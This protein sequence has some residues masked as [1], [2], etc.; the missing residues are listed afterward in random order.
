MWLSDVSVKHPIFAIVINLLLIIFGLITLNRLAL[1]EYPAIDP[2][3]ISIETSYPGAAAAT[4]ETRITKILEDRISGIEGIAYI[5][6]N[7]EDGF[8]SIN[9]EF[10][11]NRNIDNAAN[12]VRERVNRVLSDL[13][14]DAE[15][16]EIFKADS[17]NDVIIWLNLSSDKLNQLQLTDYANRYLVDRLA[18]V[19]GVARVRIGG[20][21]RY[22]MR[23][24]I[25][26]IAMAAR[27]ITLTDIE[28]A[29]RANNV[30]L[31]GGRIESKT[32]EFTVRIKRKF[33]T[34]ND[35]AK[36]V[37]RRDSNGHIIRLG[38]VAKIKVAA[39]NRRTELRGNGVNMIGLGVIK[40]SNANTLDV[41]KGIR[42]KVAEIKKSLPT[43]IKLHNSYDSS[44]F[45]SEAVHGVF[46]TFLIALA[47]VVIIIYLFLGKISTVI[48]P[49]ITIPVSIIATFIILY[50]QHYSL[51][52]LTLLALV[53]A[54]GLVVDDSIVVLENI[55]RRWH[56][57]EPPLLASYRGTRQVGFA[58]ISTTVVL[59]AIF[60][61][62][63]LFQG[64]VG[65]LFT[66]F[67]FTLSAAVVFSSIVALTLSPVLCSLI[68]GVG[69][70]ETRLEKWANKIHAFL[71]Y[72]YKKA[73]IWSLAHKK[74]WVIIF[75]LVSA[76]I[77]LLYNL[78]PQE[79]VPEEDRGAFYVLVNGPEGAS[80]SYM[81]KNMRQ[82]E[83]TLMPL[84]NNK[85]ATRVLTIVPR[86]FGR[87]D[88]VNSGFGI[89]VMSHW[90]QRKHSTQA[91]IA[92]IFP[93]LLSV[94]GVQAFPIMR[95]GIAHSGTQQQV[96]FVIGGSN[97]Q[98]LAIWRDTI[99]NY[100]KKNKK[101]L[102]LDSDYKETTPQLIIDINRD[103]AAE[104]GVPMQAIGRT[105][106]TLLGA[107]KVTTYINDDEE[108]EVML[109]LNLQQKQTPRDI[110]YIYVRSSTTNRLIPLSNLITVHEIN[111][112][113][114]LHR[115]NRLRA[116]TISA[117]LAPGYTLDQA[118]QFLEKIALTHLPKTVNIDYKGTSR[119]YKESG[120]QIIFIFI[121]AIMVTFLV[122]AALFGSFIHPII[123]LVTAPLAIS[124]ALFGLF[125]SG[126]TLNIYSKIGIIMLIGLS[127][128]NG[129]LMVEFINQLR[130]QNYT[131][132]KAIVEAACIRLRPILMTALS[133]IFGAIPLI[134]A[135]GAGSESRMTIGIVIFFG[136]SLTT[137]L[138]LFIVPVFY[139][140]LAQKTFPRNYVANKVVQLEAEHKE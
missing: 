54:I 129:I 138:T 57:G 29:L 119:E 9:I 35:F 73:L 32:R 121:L 101:L 4:V 50:I 23:I 51:N 140:L 5:E 127:A 85:E 60:L 93:Q 71:Q 69:K 19:N 111:A 123:I 46:I 65:R 92:S 83:N 99:L 131:F 66:E 104:L 77:L 106:E 13:P 49:A 22:A 108:Y 8:S 28:A 36:L 25:D 128:K 39:E 10:T 62:I 86:G 124:G 56:L 120:L 139:Q 64:Y 125:I 126:S 59:L 48:V 100:A 113:N 107:R 88:A 76:V 110:D 21:K 80:F 89:V 98:E 30:E 118:L 34:P 6:S 33:Q 81:Q 24:W 115:Y 117:S 7:S 90:N 63:S 20:E 31:P 42:E 1:R 84:V 87:A 79:L 109:E 137:L 135:T 2:P 14:Q 78:V 17:D 37:I 94:P 47:L 75:I 103:R 130:E 67:A 116:I 52:L 96:Q 134:I 40:Q 82:I 58:V 18:V 72:H 61:P 41:A 91:A 12:D 136:V 11:I 26:K 16:P 74:F 55:T 95:S 102:N 122:L 114:A 15:P 3:I 105:L 27:D 44:I 68:L 97:Y 45:V 133:T 53:L 38:E 70:K 43:E 112:P 132:K